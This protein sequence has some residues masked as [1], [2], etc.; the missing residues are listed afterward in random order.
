MRRAL[1]PLVLALALAMALLHTP[2]A[3]AEHLP[4]HRYFIVGTVTDEAGDP[5]C[6][7]TVRAADIDKPAAD[8]NRT[9]VTDGSGAYSI[10]LHMH[11][12]FDI[13]ANQPRPTH[14][15]GDQILVTTVNDSAVVRADK[16]TR[17]PNGWGQQTVPLNAVGVRGQCPEPID[18]AITAIGIA[19]VA[20]AIIVII[21]L[22]RRPRR[23][24]R[25][26]RAGLRQISSVG[27]ARARELEG[28]GIRGV[29]DLAA[30]SPDK[31]SAGTTLTPKQARLLVK[32]ANEA[33]GKKA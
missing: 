18:L 16:N 22:V 5:V 26:S 3:R 10:Q 21:W 24:G 27:R 14:N 23:L 33:L 29:E 32:R 13:E 6:G 28:F 12:S 8:N 2:A 25:G 17:N 31:L 11:D 7:V 1:V 15:V 19:G 20:A 4:D 30:A 9:A